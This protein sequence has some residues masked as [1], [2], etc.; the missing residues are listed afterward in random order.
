M[1]WARPWR[2]RS[3]FTDPPG[4]GDH[5]LGAFILLFGVADF[6][7]QAP[8]RCQPLYMGI[9]LSHSALTFVGNRC[10]RTAVVDN[11]CLRA[12]GMGDRCVLTAIGFSGVCHIIT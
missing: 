8:R 7:L 11:R 12:S 3:L 4:V 5:C 2:L 1:L 10:I 9:N 6:C